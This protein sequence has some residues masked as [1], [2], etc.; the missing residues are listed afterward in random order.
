MTLWFY[1]V[2]NSYSIE[3][4]FLDEWKTIKELKSNIDNLDKTNIK[5]DNDLETLNADYELKSFLKKD[6]VAVELRKIREII[7]E[8]NSNKIKLEIILSN[9]SKSL[10][11]VIKERKLLLEEKRKLYS[12]L[13]PYINTQFKDKYL[14][15][16]KWDA[17]IF[18]EQND[19][20]SDI[21]VKKEILSTK[22]ETIETKIREHKDF[23]NESIRKIIE[24]RLDTK[25]NSLN[26]NETFK[27]LNL[28]SKI[29]VIEKTIIKVKIKLQNLQK[30]KIKTST[31]ITIKADSTIL[32]KKI[33]TY[34]IAVDKLEE[35]KKDLK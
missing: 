1:S 9:K 2:T 29:K 11:P 21:I 12:G 4:A 14:E 6:L 8:Y 28:E 16:I 33:E 25:I 30:S 3:L 35:F 19:I 23:I 22:V 27:K 15:Y 24:T 17:K 32:D 34:N 26:D 10:L 31:W 20:T 13:I 5:L 18:N 7:S